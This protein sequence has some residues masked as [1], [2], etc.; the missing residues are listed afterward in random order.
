MKTHPGDRDEDHEYIFVKSFFHR[1]LG[2]R[3][4]AW[5]Y[6]KKAFRL[7]IRRKRVSKAA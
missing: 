3:I 2:R 4:Y 5:Q 7:K 1:G 6:G